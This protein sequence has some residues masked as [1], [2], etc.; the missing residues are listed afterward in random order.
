MRARIG[1]GVLLA[2]IMAAAGAGAQTNDAL[3]ARE[4]AACAHDAVGPAANLARYEACTLIVA[5]A[6]GVELRTAL[7]DRATALL[8]LGRLDAAARDAEAALSA[9]PD[10]RAYSLRA[11]ALVRLGR[12]EEALADLDRAVTLAPGQPDPLHE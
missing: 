6:A 11:R 10:L 12:D 7:L 9:A 3:S 1:G 4:R 2:A 8:A 5:A